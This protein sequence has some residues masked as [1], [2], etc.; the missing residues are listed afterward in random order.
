[1]ALFSP[2]DEPEP[3]LQEGHEPWLARGE[4]AGHVDC[5]FVVVDLNDVAAAGGSVNGALRLAFPL[6]SSC[7]VE[8]VTLRISMS[9]SSCIQAMTLQFGDSSHA[10]PASMWLGGGGQVPSRRFS[11]PAL[12]F[13]MNVTPLPP[14]FDRRGKK[15]SPLTAGRTR[16]SSSSSAS[17][18]REQTVKVPGVLLKNRCNC[19]YN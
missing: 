4:T 6:A 2:A 8:C 9:Q 15:C 17:A 10:A 11:K 14:T 7:W 5:G 16:S 3:F 12:S 18:A 19:R 1:M 13:M